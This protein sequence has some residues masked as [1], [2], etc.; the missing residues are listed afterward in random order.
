M[1]R[2]GVFEDLTGQRFG[3]VTVLSREPSL[4]SYTTRWKVECDCGTVYIAM[5]VV[6]KAR[7]KLNGK[8]ACAA[9][10]HEAQRS[11]YP[12]NSPEYNTWHGMKA[13]CT[14]EN[15]HAWKNYGGRGIKVCERWL[16]SYENFYEDMGPK[17]SPDHSLDRIDNDADYSPE[18]CRWATRAE[19]MNN[20]RRTTVISFRGELVKLSELESIAGVSKGT[21]IKRYQAGH[22]EE[23]LVN[24]PEERVLS[25][26]ALYTYLGETHTLTGWARKYGL[27]P[28]TVYARFRVGER[29]EFLFR[30]VDEI[31]KSEAHLV[32]WNGERHT[33]TEWE[34]LTGINRVTLKDRLKRGDR[35]D[36]LFRP[37]R[38]KKPAKPRS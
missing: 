4:V 7:V 8:Y 22:R 30:S 3:S 5:A 29:G 36:R 31:V 26:S 6:M 35:G 1:P 13:R 24:L 27:E 2:K 16:N 21:L 15:H 23:S 18:N 32:E 20:T 19:Q 17:P 25:N 28:S 34:R 38:P 9:C 14:N 33:L 11:K 10:G 37:A 12:V